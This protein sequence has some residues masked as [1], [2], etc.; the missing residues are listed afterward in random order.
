MLN[1]LTVPEYLQTTGM[2][3]SIP[4]EFTDGCFQPFLFFLSGILLPDV[5]M[6]TP[7]YILESTIVKEGTL[8][9]SYTTN[10]DKL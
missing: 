2:A 9:K 10:G 5:Y 3:L 8:S 6:Q 1:P 4:S 7:I